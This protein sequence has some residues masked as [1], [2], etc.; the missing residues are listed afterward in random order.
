MTRK[1]MI[2]CVACGSKLKTKPR[3]KVDAYDGETGKPLVFFG[4]KVYCPSLKCRLKCLI[5]LKENS[6]YMDSNGQI[7]KSEISGM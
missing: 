1:T 3:R 6:Y 7:R 4:D 2:Y 5:A